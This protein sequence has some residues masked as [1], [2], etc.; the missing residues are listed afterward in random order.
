MSQPTWTIYGTQGTVTYA[1]ETFPTKREAVKKMMSL[2]QDKTPI[3][4][5]GHKYYYQVKKG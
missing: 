1:P 4:R 3:V 2:R 5:D